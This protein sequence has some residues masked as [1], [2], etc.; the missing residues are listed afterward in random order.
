MVTAEG[1]EEDSEEPLPLEPLEL[2]PEELVPEEVLSEP[3][4]L[5][6]S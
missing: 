5:L 6:A 4:E 2:L 3:E 1:V